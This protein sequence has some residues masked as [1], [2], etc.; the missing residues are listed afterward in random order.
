[1]PFDEIIVK[2]YDLY[3]EEILAFDKVVIGTEAVGDPP[4]RRAITQRRNLAS[5]P[6]VELGNNC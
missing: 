6:H 2:I 1:M 5:K 4:R 3:F